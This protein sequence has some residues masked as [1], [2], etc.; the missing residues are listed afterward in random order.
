[1]YVSFQSE[2]PT[3]DEDV[4]SRQKFALLEAPRRVQ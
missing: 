2:V 4:Q 3:K 1:M